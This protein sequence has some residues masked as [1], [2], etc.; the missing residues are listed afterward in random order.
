MSF[1]LHVAFPH[2]FFIVL[3]LFHVVYIPLIYHSL[4]MQGS[5]KVTFILGLVLLT[6]VQ[7]HRLG[8]PQGEAPVRPSGVPDPM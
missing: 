2:L 8:D 1:V 6:A 7:V 5:A 3:M 4:P